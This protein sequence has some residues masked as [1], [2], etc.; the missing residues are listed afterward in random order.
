MAW[1]DSE[2]EELNAERG[3]FIA[4]EAGAVSRV[5]QQHGRNAVLEMEYGRCL[6]GIESCRPVRR[7]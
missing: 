5:T 6:S 1:L 4:A 3:E 7:S 2:F